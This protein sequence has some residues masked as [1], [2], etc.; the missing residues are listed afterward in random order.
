MYFD[1][2]LEY[3]ALVQ[4]TDVH[5]RIV[6]EERLPEGTINHYIDT[7]DLLEKGVYFLTILDEDFQIRKYA[8][9]FLRK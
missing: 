3:N 8:G 2:A 5:G 4:L 7:S 1:K 6:M 9:K